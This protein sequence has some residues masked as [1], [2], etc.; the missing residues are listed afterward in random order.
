MAV[1]D[2]TQT[3]LRNRWIIDSGSS[4]HVVNTEAWNDWKKTSDNPDRRTLNAGN[5]CLLITA[6]CTMEPV[7]RTT[8]VNYC[9]PNLKPLHLQVSTASL[10][11]HL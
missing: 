3:E 7:A 1:D 8:H 4:T 10:E 5:S 2:T 6:W 11:P 9:A